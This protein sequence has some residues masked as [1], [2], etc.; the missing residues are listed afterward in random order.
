M[1]NV[2]IQ[3]A[4]EEPENEANFTQVDVLLQWSAGT[5]LVLLSDDNEWLHEPKH[6]AQGTG[7]GHVRLLHGVAYADHVLPSTAVLLKQKLINRHVTF[8]LSSYCCVLLG[9][10]QVWL[11]NPGSK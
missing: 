9:G 6:T 8:D 5:A 2:E 4:V 1:L 10:S 3:E 7:S 11:Q